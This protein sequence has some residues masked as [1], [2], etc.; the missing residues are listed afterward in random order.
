MGDAAEE[1]GVVGLSRDKSRSRLT[2]LFPAG[3]RVEKEPT[4][5]LR[6]LGVTFVAFLRED[7]ADAR[8]EEFDLRGVWRGDQ[9]RCQGGKEGEEPG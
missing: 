6:C 2:A 8:F 9:R 7:G 1:E 3:A 4:P 5:C